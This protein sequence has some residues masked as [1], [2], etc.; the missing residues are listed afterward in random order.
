MIAAIWFLLLGTSVLFTKHKLVRHLA[1]HCFIMFMCLLLCGLAGWPLAAV[2]ETFEYDVLKWLNNVS[3]LRDAQKYIGQQ[4][5]PH[6][7]ALDWGFRFGGSVINSRTVSN[8]VVGMAAA[9]LGTLGQAIFELS[10][11]TVKSS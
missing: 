6:L 2:A 10:T 8:V 5:L 9:L 11:D 4:T 3:V 7:H 1:R